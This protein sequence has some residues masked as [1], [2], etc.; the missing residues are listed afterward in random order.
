MSERS[1]PD[2]DLLALA[3][4]AAGGEV[5]PIAWIA[6]RLVARAGHLA[7]K[8]YRDP[9]RL[10]REV[11][12]GELARSV[13]IPLPRQVGYRP[14]PPA[15]LITE[16]IEG[17]PLDRHPGSARDLGRLLQPYYVARPAP[18]Q[19][20]PGWARE[21]E[22]RVRLEL[23]RAAEFGLPELPDDGEL[24]RL[25]ELARSRPQALIHG[26]LQPEHVLVDPGNGRIVA[27]LDFADSGF[28]DPLFE[29]AR[30]GLRHPEL[31]QPFLEGLG[32]EPDSALRSAYRTLWS[33]MTA[34]WLVEHGFSQLPA[35]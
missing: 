24:S 29:A 30:L 21:L 12:Y 9:E 32:I 4:E 26:D 14:G 22:R 5:S 15:A 20:A 18:A 17:E 35:E 23:E 33:L 7:L 27:V 16:W 3:A 31:E 6:G 28:A 1:G 10:E 19:A 11:E 34:T 2:P 13:G 8:V 25:P